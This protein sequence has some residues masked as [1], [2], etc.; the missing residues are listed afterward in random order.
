M[1]I[2]T[3]EEEQEHY[4]YA[5]RMTCNQSGYRSLPALSATVRGGL[6]GGAIGGL[7]G[8]AGVWGAS[9]RYPFFNSLTLPFKAFLV[10]SS[11]TFAGK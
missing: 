11:G 6:G 1:K 4:K 3:K 5:C 9:K 2:L 10:V 7:A 8:F